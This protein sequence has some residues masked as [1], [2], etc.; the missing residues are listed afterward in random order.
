MFHPIRR[1]DV[2][3]AIFLGLALALP[4]VLSPGVDA[5]GYGVAA[6]AAVVPA[7]VPGHA[8][9]HHHHHAAFR[10][11]AVFAAPVYVAPA[12]V[13]APAVSVYVPP[14]QVVRQRTVFRAPRSYSYPAAS[15]APSYSYPQQTFA[16]SYAPAVDACPAP[17]PA[18]APGCGCLG[19]G[20]GVPYR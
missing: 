8:P 16:P 17:A 15:F 7:P 5:G 6:S 18:P 4:C 9:R 12:V 14:A 1:T 2:K 10:Q 13:A 19:G 3:A 20:A 11:R